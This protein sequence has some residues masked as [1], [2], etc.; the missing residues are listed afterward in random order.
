MFILW[1]LE[2]RYAA[3][4]AK[5]NRK[6]LIIAMLVFVP[7]TFVAFFFSLSSGWP[8]AGPARMA[9]VLSHPIRAVGL[10]EN[11][12]REA[13]GPLAQP[14]NSCDHLLVRVDREGILPRC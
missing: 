9:G 2:K 4:S 8:N 10:S 12:E 5:K 3:G 1:R 11:G 14:A 7:A 13:G 6:R